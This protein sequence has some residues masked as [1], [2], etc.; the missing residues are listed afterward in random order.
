MS[1]WHG[2]WGR[3][4]EP[5]HGR[6]GQVVGSVV[7]DPYRECWRACDLGGRGGEAEYATR[8]QAE[9]AVRGQAGAL[10]RQG[11]ATRPQASGEGLGE[12]A[13]ALKAGAALVG[14][15]AALFDGQT[16]SQAQADELR[17]QN[18]ELRRQN[19]LLREALGRMGPQGLA[20]R[21]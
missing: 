21:R 16:Q 15:L 1:K 17:R 3:A 20:R 8:G 19:E 7:Y 11:Q 6:D 10:V 4:Q 2:D 13:E 12:L 14:G 5:V 18:D 9:R